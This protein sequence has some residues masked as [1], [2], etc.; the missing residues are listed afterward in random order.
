LKTAVS[1][2]KKGEKVCNS[3]TAV[4]ITFLC[5]HSHSHA[6]V[7]IYLTFRIKSNCML[8]FQNHVP[9]ST[10]YTNTRQ[11]CHHLLLSN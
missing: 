9:S 5:I 7:F 10:A 6:L 11:P 3:G 2:T 1:F 8:S 4:K